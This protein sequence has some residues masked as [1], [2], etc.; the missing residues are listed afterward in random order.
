MVAVKIR[1][2]NCG[3]SKKKVIKILTEY[4]RSNSTYKNI[5]RRKSNC[6]SFTKM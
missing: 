1:M 5:K 3:I 4:K 2:L 6:S